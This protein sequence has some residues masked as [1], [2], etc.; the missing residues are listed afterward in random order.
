MA[1]RLGQQRPYPSRMGEWEGRCCVCGRPDDE[2]GEELAP[3]PDGSLWCPRCLLPS[4]P[5]Q[6]ESKER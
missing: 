2:L 4:V 5:A 1:E 6:R 3:L